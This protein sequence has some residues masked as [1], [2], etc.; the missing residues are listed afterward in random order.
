[1]QVKSCGILVNV[2]GHSGAVGITQSDSF[3]QLTIGGVHM[4]AILPELML[5]GNKWDQK[6]GDFAIIYVNG[7]FV[8]IE[9]R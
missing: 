2:R 5:T 1:M 4:L 8:V 7:P 6:D 3:C 9:C